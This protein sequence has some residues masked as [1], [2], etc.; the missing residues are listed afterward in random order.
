MSI[1]NHF[2]DG[3]AKKT[4]V[5]VG[6]NQTPKLV[7]IHYSV[8]DTVAQAVSALNAAKHGYHILIEKDGTGVFRHANSP[9]LP[10][11]RVCPTGKRGKASRSTVP[12]AAARSASAL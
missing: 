7:V 12:L 10:P 8:T 9:S 5:H 3:L 6:T 4:L 1:T 11:I 2:V